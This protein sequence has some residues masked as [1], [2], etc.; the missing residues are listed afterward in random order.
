M[1]DGV[2]AETSQTVRLSSEQCRALGLR[3]I[4]PSRYTK[5]SASQSQEQMSTGGE[6][7]Q[8][9][10]RGRAEA[11]L[12]MRALEAM[13]AEDTTAVVESRAVEC[14][15]ADEETEGA[16]AV[17]RL[18]VRRQ[19]EETEAVLRQAEETEAILERIAQEMSAAAAAPDQ[20]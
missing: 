5:G 14:T 13:S 2:A 20:P 17:R 15:I 9:R 18:F 4:I 3:Y 8:T 12:E 6:D 19:A 1:T 10:V 16:A 7:E 11:I